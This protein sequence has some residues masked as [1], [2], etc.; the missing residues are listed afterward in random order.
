MKMLRFS[1]ILS[2]D[3]H[4]L[5]QKIVL[6]ETVKLWSSFMINYNLRVPKLSMS[7]LVINRLGLNKLL[8]EKV[9]LTFFTTRS[10]IFVCIL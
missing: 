6:T 2:V 9:S 7:A 5:I 10:L 1:F 3:V 4:M 8:L